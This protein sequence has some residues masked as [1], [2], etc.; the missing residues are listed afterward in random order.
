MK[1]YIVLSLYCCSY[2]LD[3]SIAQEN[4][5]YREHIKNLLSQ[6]NHQIGHFLRTITT[7]GCGD[8]DDI[9]KVQGAGEIFESP[10]GTQYQLMHNGIK[11]LR[12]C[13]YDDGSTWM[14]W[15]I[16]ALKGHHE[17]QEEKLFYEVLKHIPADA[18]M[19]ELG[20]YWA[21]Y[22]LWFAQTIPDAHN[23]IIEPDQQRLQIGKN[24]FAL[25]E[26]SAN[27]FHG[28]V[29]M[30]GNDT[31]AGGDNAPLISID[32][33]LH[34]QN[35]KHLHILHADVQGAEYAML[36]TCEEALHKNK[37]D[38]FFISTHSAYLHHQCLRFFEKHNFHVIAEHTMAESF[39]CDGLIVAKRKDVAGPDRVEISK[40]NFGPEILI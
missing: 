5:K 27:F 8:V 24:N 1:K 12:D 22:S 6:E 37:I 4:K 26:K 16:H 15:I 31:I 29:G 40:R 28:Y 38:F 34:E 11:M 10:D 23:Y 39:S 32:A 36:L 21:Y 18:T 9:P 2:F 30:K 14:T 20:A 3:A 7:I 35:I 33:F 17:P 19:L 13:Y 25:N